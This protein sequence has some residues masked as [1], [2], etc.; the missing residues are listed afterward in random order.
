MLIS[1]Q[2]G[3]STA[4]TS[5]N[6]IF[7]TLWPIPV[8]GSKRWPAAL[9]DIDEVISYVKNQNLGF[10]VPYTMNGQERN[11]YPDFLVR[12]DDGRGPN[13]LL[14]LIIEVTGEQKKDKPV[15]TSTARTLWIPAINNHSGF[16]RWS[17]LEI[18]DPWDAKNI[19][20]KYLGQLIEEVVKP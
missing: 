1:I 18:T 2:F 20:R 6:A 12:I 4:Q 5:Q 17:F 7:H 14:N 10:T 9:E 16:G 11:Y 3:P 13:D 19:V 15:K 8:R